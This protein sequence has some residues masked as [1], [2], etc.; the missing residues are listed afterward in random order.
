MS[1][2]DV[3]RALFGTIEGH[4]GLGPETLCEGDEVWIF[5]RAPVPLGSSEMLRI[6]KIQSIPVGGQCYVHGI[7]HGETFGNRD[8][9]WEE[10]ELE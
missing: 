8:P 6:K 3:G 2:L 4:I 9:V 10:V 1:Q 7:M 5:A